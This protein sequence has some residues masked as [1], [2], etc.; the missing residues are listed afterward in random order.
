MLTKYRIGLHKLLIFFSAKERQY[1]MNPSF[2]YFSN[3]PSWFHLSPGK[4]WAA[5]GGEA[6]IWGNQKALLCP[7]CSGGDPC[8]QI[9]E[10]WPS[11]CVVW[12]G[13]GWG[14]REQ[15]TCDIH[16]NSRF[17][18]SRS[19]APLCSHFSLPSGHL[20]CQV[21]CWAGND[22]LWNLSC[23]TWGWRCSQGPLFLP[24]TVTE[25]LS[26]LIPDLSLYQVTGV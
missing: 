2:L 13:T 11:V 17:R 21:E 4:Q 9:Q 8:L 24:A 6:G 18:T 20:K 14:M 1:K 5:R 26:Q 10:A 3:L 15:G 23:I 22:I 25:D 16:S 12:D 7:F 19:R